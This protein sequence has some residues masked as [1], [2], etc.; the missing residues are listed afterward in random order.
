MPEI[1]YH[2][3][4]LATRLSKLIMQVSVGSSASSGV[5]LAAPRRTGKSTF[6]RE[7][8]R[9]ALE[10]AGAIV[11]YADLWQDLTKDPGLVIVEAIREAV[12][13]SDGFITRLAKASGVEKVVVGGL[14]FSVDKIGLGRDI[15]LT[16]ALVALSDESKKLI[17]LM[18]DEAQHA[19]TTEAGVA[20]LF[21][22][23]AA[24]DELNSSRHHGLRIVCTGSNRDKLAMLRNS[25]D[26]A[27]FGASMVPFPTL[28]QNYIDWLCA[29]IDLPS[30]LDPAE[31]FQLFKESG[32]RP[33]L[34]GAA[35]DAIRFDFFIDP[36][37]VPER[38]AELVRAQADELNANLKKVIHSLT[39]IQS[40]VIRVMGSMGDN[41]APF[42]APTM[43]LYATAMKQSGVAE[44]AIKVE[45]PGVQQ[46]LIALQEKNLVWKASRGVYAVDE[47][48]IVDLL[49][50]DGLLD[51]L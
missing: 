29:N 19:I 49:R 44:S 5:F 45:V 17:V 9:P 12:G 4:E 22:L 20:A 38:F 47:H 43:A 3:P 36:E 35:A 51:G 48:V 11:L 13:R 31:V 25:K 10:K 7:D 16:T 26:Q 14:N 41:F 33:E 18:I 27:F 8:L 40:A 50:A 37:N 2:R 42:E 39:P 32:Y 34:L 30:P 21:A 28:D 15:D 6:A 1:L 24:R 23:K 46:A